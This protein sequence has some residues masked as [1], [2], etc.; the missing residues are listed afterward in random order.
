MASFDYIV[1]GAGSAGCVVASR[2]SED[3]TK[4]VLLLEAGGSNRSLLYHIPIMM[5]IVS[6]RRSNLWDIKTD[7]EEGANNR[8]FAP[9]RGKVIGGSSSINAMI[10]ARGHPLDYDQWRQSG[11]DGWG[12]ADLLPYFKRSEGSWREND[13]YHNDSGELKVSRSPEVDIFYKLFA[14]SAAAA[15]LKL[16]PDFNGADPEGI[17]WPDMTL[18]GGWR[19]S[20]ARQ[21]LRPAENRR[22]LTIE[23]NAL[24]HKVI[25]ENGKATGVEYSQDGAV[26]VARCDGEV[27]LSGGTYNSPHLL[28]LSG[29]GP[30][31]EL[32][33]HGIDVIADRPDVGRNLQEHVNVITVVEPKDPISLDSK[34]RYDKLTIE[35]LKWGLF[36]SGLL[37]SFPTSAVGFVRVRPES[38][39]PD[40]E[41]IST[42]VWQDSNPWFPGIKKRAGHRFTTRLAVLHPRSRG[43]VKL[44][45]ADPARPPR[46]KWN[47][48]SDPIDLETLR[49]GVKL[50]RRIHD[51]GPYKSLLKGE[52]APG[53]NVKTDAEIDEWLRNNCQTAQHPASTC[54]MGTDDDAV[55]DAELRVKGVEGIRVADCSIMPYVTGCNTNAPAIMIGEKCADLIRGRRLPAAEV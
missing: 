38:E 37:A 18:R 4:R 2:L 3:P 29:I 55:V 43:Y 7:P 51:S 5:R 40:V 39:R 48:F 35:A 17:S 19:S 52:I 42:P 32:R 9:P 11:L 53:P 20:A 10:Y 8:V 23:I 6:R 54:R 31:D 14:D 47:L 16:T 45:S 12:Y 27:V 24:A 50:A 26:K 44:H 34:L 25:V 46:V 13:A 15:G 41:I 1:V 30:A 21:F 49:E 36:R 22:N 28:L 33:A